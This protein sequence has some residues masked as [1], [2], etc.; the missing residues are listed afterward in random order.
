MP[1][2]RR[3]AWLTCNVGQRMNPK[4]AIL[5][6]IPAIALSGCV[7]LRWPTTPLVS[8]KIYDAASGRPIAGASVFWIST[9]EKKEKSQPDGSYILP[10]LGRT[11][12]VF[13]MGDFFVGRVSGDVHVDAAGF[14]SQEGIVSET[15]RGFGTADIKAS[16]DFSLAPAHAK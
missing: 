10:S 8:G 15:S 1:L 13:P 4:L 9:P 11:R 2:V 16:R 7:P 6:C 3:R 12:W 14:E 5:L